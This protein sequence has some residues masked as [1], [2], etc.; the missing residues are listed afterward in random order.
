[1]IVYWNYKN[2]IDSV[3]NLFSINISS[4]FTSSNVIN[5]NNT[6]WVAVACTFNDSTLK[7]SGGISSYLQTTSIGFKGCLDIDVLSQC[8]KVMS[9]LDVLLY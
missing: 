8:D 5:I 1:M 6:K 7:L 3:H 9:L 4:S 2:Q